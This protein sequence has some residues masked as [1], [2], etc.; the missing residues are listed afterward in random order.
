M[1][2]STFWSRIFL[3]QHWKCHF[4]ALNMAT[5]PKVPELGPEKKV[6]QVPVQKPRPLL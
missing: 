5:L 1:Q 2:N 4:L 6:L 3:Y